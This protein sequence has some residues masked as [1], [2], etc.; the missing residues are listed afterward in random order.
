MKGPHSQWMLLVTDQSQDAQ[1]TSC[2]IFTMIITL[3]WRS[4]FNT[5]FT[6]VRWHFSLIINLSIT[7]FCWFAASRFCSDILYSLSLYFWMLL[8]LPMT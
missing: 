6:A 5:K 2:L 3:G 7:S 1:P 8:Y 4:H